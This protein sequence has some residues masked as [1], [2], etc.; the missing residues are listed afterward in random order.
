[1]IVRKENLRILLRLPNWLGDSVMVSP[2]FELLKEYFENATFDL[3]G[4]KASCEIYSRDLRVKNIFID[5]TK[6]QNNRIRAT[7]DFAKIVGKH[8]IAITFSN[9]FFSALFL[10]ATKTPIRI[11]YG[12]NLRSFLLTNRIPFIKNIH[13]VLSYINLVNRLCSRDLIH[14]NSDI[15]DVKGLKLIS[16][17]I[18][19]FH[20]DETK[21]YI[22]I[23]PG[24][25]YGSAKKW[26]EKYFVEIIAHF[27][28]DD[29][30][31]LLFG[32]KEDKAIEAIEG[33][34]GRYKNLNINNLVNLAGETTIH[35]LCD[36]IALLDLFITNDSGPMHI[37]AS[38]NI[39]II[40]MFGPTDSKET[41]PWKA[42]AILINKHLSCSP[43]K[44]R[45]CPLKHHNCMKLIT[46]DEVIYN[47]YKL[48][49]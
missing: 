33:L 30:I 36:Y 49:K 44:K 19:N 27:L 23:N 5:E 3:V 1:M 29:H 15:S 9:T 7:L 8:D 13:Q 35:Q 38:Y 43:C 11:G 28:N 4:T 25:A 42:N 26:E 6:K 10:Y 31:I 45:E 20:K 34:L 24:A 17:K 32:N 21:R 41:S 18:K 48:L 22:G 12:R 39:P 40:A 2:S 37:A 46:P 14:H 16:Q 47:A